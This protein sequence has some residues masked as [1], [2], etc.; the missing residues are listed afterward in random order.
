MQLNL[1]RQIPIDPAQAVVIEYQIG[2]RKMLVSR[3]PLCAD[4]GDGWGDCKTK[5]LP[6]SINEAFSRAYFPHNI[7]TTPALRSETV[8]I[9]ALV[10]CS[11]PF[12]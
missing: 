2:L 4:N 6:V 3:K 11:H 8:L 7:K 5:C 1:L 10:N 9:T 12:P